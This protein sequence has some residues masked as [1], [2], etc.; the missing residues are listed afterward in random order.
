MQTNLYSV[1]RL[2][3]LVPYYDAAVSCGK[4]KD[5]GDVMAGLWTLLPAGLAVGDTYVTRAE[6]D[7]MKGVGILTGDRL[8]MEV[9]REYRSHDIVLVEVD[10]ERLLKTYYEDEAGRRWLVPAN[11]DYDPLLLT[12]DMEV[13]FLARMKAHIRE[14]VHDTTRHLAQMIRRSP[15]YEQR[16]AGASEVMP[17]DDG[18][19]AVIELTDGLMADMLHSV[20][21]LVKS[22]RQWYAAYRVLITNHLVGNGDLDYF[23]AAVAK[24]LPDHPKLPV[25]NQLQRV[26]MGC[27][28]LPLDQW[29]ELRAPVRGTT[30]YAYL[31]VGERMQQELESLTH[32]RRSN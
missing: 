30:Y 3:T 13:R 10:G 11:D 31:R 32:S 20:G 14:N 6:G 7:S 27:F 17:P 25:K 1:E 19:F 22:S 15:D 16:S 28:K 2:D 9:A 4:P 23:C 12:D 18:G 21:T 8:V 24:L 29:T 5:T 26:D